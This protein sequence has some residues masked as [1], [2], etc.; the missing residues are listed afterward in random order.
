MGWGDWRGGGGGGPTQLGIRFISHLAEW[1]RFV[2]IR[3]LM[4]FAPEK[5]AP[6]LQQ[7]FAYSNVRP[8]N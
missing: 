3:R 2:V 6:Q 8:P 7:G 4:V 1:K 5:S